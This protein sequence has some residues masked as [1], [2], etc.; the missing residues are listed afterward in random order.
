MISRLIGAEH[1]ALTVPVED[2]LRGV[3]PRQAVM[4]PVLGRLSA[5]EARV[6]PGRAIVPDQALVHLLVILGRFTTSFP[7]RTLSS[8]QLGVIIC[9]NY[10]ASMFVRQGS[11]SESFGY[12][13]TPLFSSV[14]AANSACRKLSQLLLVSFFVGPGHDILGPLPMSAAG[15]L[16]WAFPS[17][18]H[19]T[20]N[21]IP[22]RRW[23]L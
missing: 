23:P 1:Q 13:L 7:R 6:I 17:R 3:L 21:N 16:G 9:R 5:V 10:L 15:A 11:S 18:G 22:L 2:F 20:N 19:V 12:L 14:L 8:L 4:R